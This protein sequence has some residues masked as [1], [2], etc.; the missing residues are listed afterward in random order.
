MGVRDCLEHLPCRH[1]SPCVGRLQ[2]VDV[3]ALLTVIVTLAFRSDVA[4]LCLGAVGR[5]WPADTIIPEIIM[6]D[7]YHDVIVNMHNIIYET[8]V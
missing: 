6:Y 4:C 2:L 7:M 3:E 8:D 5:R 1:S